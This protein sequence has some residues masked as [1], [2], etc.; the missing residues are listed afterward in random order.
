MA[1]A[2]LGVIP[3]AYISGGGFDP[4]AYTNPIVGIYG[5]F[6]ALWAVRGLCHVMVLRDSQRPHINLGRGRS[7]CSSSGSASRRPST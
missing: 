6:V 4:D 1:P 2:L 5:M 7:P 3:F